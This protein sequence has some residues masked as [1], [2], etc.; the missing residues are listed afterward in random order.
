MQLIEEENDKLIVSTENSLDDVSISML[1]ED[2]YWFFGN[3]SDVNIYKA[4]FIT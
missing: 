2:Y 1:T 3:I 4:Y